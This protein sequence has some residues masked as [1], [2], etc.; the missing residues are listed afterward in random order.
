[1][2]FEFIRKNK[3]KIFPIIYMLQ[4]CYKCVTI[5]FVIKRFKFMRRII[6]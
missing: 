3:L 4:K 6:K 5:P 2:D 1:M